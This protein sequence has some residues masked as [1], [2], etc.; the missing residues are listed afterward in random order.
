MERDSTT[1]RQC[2]AR[3]IDGDAF[4]WI[5]AGVRER[6]VEG[7]CSRRYDQPWE[8]RVSAAV[9]GGVGGGAGA[10]RGRVSPLC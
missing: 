5:R 9:R 4:L 10:G 1:A 8:R 2:E 6:R 3:E 7:R